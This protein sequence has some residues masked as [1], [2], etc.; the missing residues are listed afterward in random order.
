ML[1]FIDLKVKNHKLYCDRIPWP[2]AKEKQN[3]GFLF[4]WI[5]LIPS[6]DDVGYIA[7]TLRK[8]Y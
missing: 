2:F 3:L 5:I 1:T 8:F 7:L 6:S 4:P